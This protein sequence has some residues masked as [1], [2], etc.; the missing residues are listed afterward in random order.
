MRTTVRLDEDLM[1]AVRG[2]AHRQGTTF[3]ALVDQAL[4]ELLLKQSQ[5]ARRQ[6]VRL[7]TFK[8][9]GLQ[10]GVDLDDSAR[11]LDLMG[12]ADVPDRR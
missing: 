7:P 8:G 4:R 5:P 3:T 6:P 9:N 2:L 12:E 11:L 10:P 1:D